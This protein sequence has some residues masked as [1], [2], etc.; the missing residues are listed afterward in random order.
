IT[1]LRYVLW[2]RDAPMSARDKRLSLLS[3]FALGA[4]LVA[5]TSLREPVLKK[6]AKK[7]ADKQE[8]LE[9]KEGP[10]EDGAEAPDD[11]GADT[12][13]PAFAQRLLGSAYN[14]GPSLWVG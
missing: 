14:I 10:A 11:E 2:K 13:S 5:Y 7:K 3:V 6:S 4:V 1:A 12:D 9:N 8:Q